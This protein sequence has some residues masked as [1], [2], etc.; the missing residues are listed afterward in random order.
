VAVGLFAPTVAWPQASPATSL[1]AELAT[2]I[3]RL[4][5]AAAVV[6]ADE[7]FGDRCGAEHRRDQ[8]IRADFDGDGRQDY[9]LLLRIGEPS[10]DPAQALRTVQLWGVVFLAKRD[11]RYRPFILFQEVDAMFPSRQVLW[12]QP[13]GRVRHGAHPER[14]L[15][16]TLPGVGSMLCE[17]T[18]R[19]FYWT[20]RGQTFREYLT[21]E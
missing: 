4:N 3:K 21:R 10:G 18:A 5:S 8:I 14:V 12:V 1:P 17:G 11:G 7:V 20:S 16:L 2:A 15:T 13:P 9:A 19:V 6:T